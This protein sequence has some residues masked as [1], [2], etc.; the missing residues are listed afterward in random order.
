MSLH[1]VFYTTF[2][3]ID[4]LP[5]FT[6]IT[7][8]I[9]HRP[10]SLGLASFIIKWQLWPPAN[11][12]TAFTMLKILC[13]LFNNYSNNKLSLKRTRERIFITATEGAVWQCVNYKS[14]PTDHAGLDWI[15]GVYKRSKE[16]SNN[17]KFKNDNCQN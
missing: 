2:I 5:C 13:L 12:C 10:H 16:Q 11:D 6:S 15:K 7:D 9:S 3:W 1:L 17:I 8:L 4:L 14:C